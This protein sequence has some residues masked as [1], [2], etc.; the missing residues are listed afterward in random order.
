MRSG[1]LLRIPETDSSADTVL[2]PQKRFFTPARSP[3]TLSTALRQFF[4]SEEESVKMPE[5]TLL[6]SAVNKVMKIGLD[7]SGLRASSAIAR[8]TCAGLGCSNI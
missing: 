8:L 1:I 3:M 5:V 7:M 6:R 2:P 4:F